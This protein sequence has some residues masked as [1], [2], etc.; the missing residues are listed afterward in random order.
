MPRT[1]CSRA[2]PCTVVNVNLPNHVTINH[3]MLG[4]GSV[5]DLDVRIGYRAYWEASLLNWLKKR[6]PQE[7]QH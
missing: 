4:V 5:F 6:Y 7:V 1:S 2:L 3:S